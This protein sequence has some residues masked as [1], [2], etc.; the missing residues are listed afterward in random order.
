MRIVLIPN[1]RSVEAAALFTDVRAYLRERNV[2]VV[3]LMCDDGMPTS[4]AIMA[5]LQPGDI[6]VALGGDG[7]IMHVAKAAAAVGCP[8]LGINGGHVGFLAGL[9]RDELSV[10]ERLIVGDYVTEDRVLLCVTVCRED[11]VHS[12]LVMN[13]AVFSRGALSRLV[14][15]HIVGDEREILTCSGDGV[16]VATPTGST[17]YSLSA[18]GPLVDPAVDCMLLTPVCPHTLDSRTRILPSDSHLSITAT[19]KDG[20]AFVTVDGEETIAFT[21]EDCVTISR[22]QETARLI[23]LKPTTFYEA[24]S[25]KL[26]DRRTI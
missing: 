25:Q 2:T 12:R 4:A 11:G 6:A 17:A 10:L 9:E 14:N 15:L 16:I 7:T 3:E 1:Y 18:G 5:A 26:T 21:A 19:A 20:E 8:V 22:A 23:R 13:E 24:F